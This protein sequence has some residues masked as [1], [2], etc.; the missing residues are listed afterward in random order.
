VVGE[1]QSGGRT[2]TVLIQ[3]D[4]DPPDDNPEAAVS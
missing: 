4:T 1:E 3:E 2:R